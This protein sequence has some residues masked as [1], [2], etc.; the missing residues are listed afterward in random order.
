MTDIQT[1]RLILLAA[2]V[3]LVLGALLLRRRR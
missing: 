2:G 3:I 1:A